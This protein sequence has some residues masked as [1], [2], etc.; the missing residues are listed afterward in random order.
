[1]SSCSTGC[2]A[3]TAAS[4]RT[5]AG[6][7]WTRPGPPGR[8]H[9]TRSNSAGLI[10][11]GAPPA[12]FAIRRAGGCGCRRSGWSLHCGPICLIR[13]SASDFVIGRA[14]SR[15]AA[16]AAGGRSP[17]AV[18]SSWSDTTART[19]KKSAERAIVISPPTNAA[20]SR[21]VFIPAN[22]G[23]VIHNL[24]AD[25][26]RMT[27]FPVMPELAQRIMALRSAP[28]ARE[29]GAAVGKPFKGPT[30]GRLGRNAV[31]L[32]AV[33]SA[34][35]MQALAES[36][37]PAAGRFAPGVAYLCGLIHI[38]GFLLLG[39]LYP[40]DIATLNQ[41]L[42]ASP[43][44]EVPAIERQLF[45]TDHTQFGGWLMSQWR[46]PA[47]V[48]A[49]VR[50]HHDETYQGPYA[51]YVSLA[52]IADR[53]IQRLEIGDARETKKTPALLKAVGMSEDTV[54]AVFQR[55]LDGRAD[56]DQLA[57]SLAGAA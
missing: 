40:A 29:L 5:A 25:I 56:L 6:S 41:A 30:E 35:L 4:T 9:P 18:M 14:R 49:V 8:G 44:A 21:A 10:P 33:Y 36:A 46:M 31:W 13:K 28:S 19:V 16:S 51:G 47:E 2:G 22:G 3:A 26:E 54:L 15:R 42:S 48:V 32:H 1:M 7:G 27:E 24:R 20:S 38:I 12:E 34:A 39:H 57:E 55:L 43:N 11:G 37:V 50:Y 52:L 45:W 23:Q 17:A 53:L